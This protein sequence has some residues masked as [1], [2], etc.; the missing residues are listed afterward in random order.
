MD[1]MNLREVSAIKDAGKTQKCTNQDF[2]SK[3][4]NLRW[5]IL[6]LK[7]LLKDKRL[8]WLSRMRKVRKIKI[9]TGMQLWNEV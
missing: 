4:L 1:M 7:Q 6:T 3:I 8:R 9:L 5:K 2:S